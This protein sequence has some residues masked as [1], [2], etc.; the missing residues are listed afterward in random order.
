[1]SSAWEDMTDIEQASALELMG[2]KRQANILSSLIS[3][4]ETVEEV[5][6]TSANSSGSAMAENEK[7]MDSIAGKSEQLTNSMQ[8]MWNNALNSDAIKYFLTVANNIIKVVDSVGLLTTALAGV[9][10]Y[11]FVIKRNSPTALWQEMTTHINNYAMA[12][13]QVGALKSLNINIGTPGTSSFNATAVNQYAAAVSSLSAK[14]QA[15][16]LS[17]QGLNAEQVRSVL[18]ANQVSDADI[19]MALA[20]NGLTQATTAST[21]A[22]G[23]LLLAKAKEKSITL[24]EEAQNYLLAHSI[25]T[26][27]KKE[28]A[29]AVVKGKISHQTA[30]EIVQSGILT[31]M[32]MKQAFSW[33]ALGTAIKT[34]FLSN[35]VGW[36]MTIISALTM[37]SPLFEDLF[38]SAEERLEDLESKWKELSDKITTASNDFKQLKSS[39]DEVIPRFA[40]L[41][42]GVDQF[43]NNMKLTDAEYEEFLSLNNQ[44]A[45]MF[46]EINNGMDSNG[47]AMLAL[48]LSA[49]TLEESLWDLVEAERAAANKEIADTMPDVL[50]NINDTVKTYKD[51]ISKVENNKNQLEGA[52]KFLKKKNYS[53]GNSVE[54][55]DWEGMNGQYAE[56]YKQWGLDVESITTGGP[57]TQKTTYTISGNIDFSQLEHNYENAIA[58]LDKEIQDVNNK[59]ASKWEQLNPVVTAWAQTDY[60]F[61]GL[62]DEMQTVAQAMIGNIDFSSLKDVDTQEEV[63][64]YITN[65]ILNKIDDLSSTAQQK[66]SS[67]MS[68]DTKNMSTQEYINE[69]NSIAKA[70]EGLDEG[71]TAT[72]ILKNTGYK[73]KIEEYDR[74]VDNIAE[75]LGEGLEDSKD[76]YDD[77]ANEYVELFSTGIATRMTDD[78]QNAFKNPLSLKDPLKL[79]G[80]VDIE[81]M[82]PIGSVDIDFSELDKL[83]EKLY[84]LEPEELTKAFDYV[85]K[86][87]IKTWDELYKAL[88][89]KTF[90][91]VLDY[92]AEKEGREK[93]LTAIEE[94][95]SATGLTSESIDNIKARYQ[96]LENYDPARLFEETANGIHLNVQALRELEDAYE[97]QN[98]KELD[99]KLEGLVN[100]YNDLTL[101]IEDCADAS[102]RASLYA[103][104]QNVLDQI[105]D[106]AEL[107]TQYAGLTSA[108]NKW[109]EAQSGPNERDMYEGVIS[110]KEELEDELSRGWLDESSRSYLELL[111]GQDLSTASYDKLLETYNKLNETV[112]GAGYDVFDFFTVD[113]DGKSTTAGIY[114]FLDTVKVAQEEL[115]KEWVKVGEDG[116]YVFDFG[117][118]GDKAVAEALGISEEL[119]Q[120]I[121]RAAADAGFEVNLDST[122]SELADF[123]DEV[124]T[125][126][127]RLKEIK[128]TEYTFNI[129]STDIKD[130][131]KQIEEAKTAVKNLENE[132]GTIKVGVDQ[133]DYENAKTLL[134]TL[135]YQKQT[136]DD[137]AVLKV[138][139]TNADAGIE[140]VIKKLVQFKTDYNNLEVQT[141][142]GADT[143]E[144]EA[145][146]KAAITSLQ[147]EDPKILADLGIDLTKSDA[148]INTAISNIAPE[149]MV[150]CGL[151]PT[152]I[153]E[154]Q[155]EETTKE[156]TVI[157]E[158]N[159]RAVTE[160]MDRTLEKP[161]K[162]IWTNETRGVK[163][164]FTAPGTITWS[165]AQKAN[166]TAHSSG[167]AFA[168]GS[169]GAP[170]TE[171]SLVG[172]L[173]P[174]ILVRN[175]RW[176]TVGENGAEF[177]QV[178]KGDIIFN[179]KQT[180]EL[181]SNGY[182][183][184]RGKSYASGTAYSSG[185]GPGRYTIT[186]AYIASSNSSSSDTKDS[187]SDAS[188]A[189]DD[190]EETLD[191]IEIRLEEINEQLDLM[192]A[193]LE[194]AVNYTHKNN[195]IDEIIGINNTKISNLTAGIKKY[196]D[197]AAKLLSKVPS[198][199]REAAQNGA[200]AITDFA[201]EANEATVEA[202]NNYRDWAQKVAD[203]KQQ[204]EEVKAEIK[205]LAI[206]KFDNAYNTGDIKS[207]IEDS[208]TEKLQTAVDYDEEKGLITSSAYYTAMMKNSNKKI[209]FLTT[210]RNA[211]QKE[212]DMAV[213]AGHI[214]KGSDEWH[215]LVNQMYEIDTA[216][217]EVSI[218]LEEFQNSINDIYWDNFDELINR[219]DYL[220]DET[221]SLI[222]LMDSDDLITEPTK[223]TYKNGTVE[224][225]TA[226]DVDWTDE[227]IASLGLYAQQM[228]IAEYQSKQYAKAIDDLNNDYK[229]GKYSEIEYL[230]KLNELKS[231]QYDSIE[232]YYDAQDAIVELNETRIDSIKEGIEAEID[233]YSELIDKKKE[234]LNVEKD[235]YDF[236]KSVAEQQ[237]SIADIQRKIAAL[238]GDNSASAVAKRKQLEAE[239]VEA[240]SELEENYYDRSVEK[241]QEAL[242]KEL[243]DF[244]TEKDAEIKK[245]DEYLTNVETVVADSLGIIQSNATGVY[246]TLNAKAQEYNLTLSDSILTPW[247]D[248]ALAVSDYQTTFDT[249][250]SSTMDQ[251]EA[252]KNKWQE[253]IDKMAETGKNTVAAINKENSSYNAATKTPAPAKPTT[254]TNKTTTTTKT[255]KT[256]GKINAGSAKIYS[257]IGGQG[258]GQYFSSDPI[259]KVLDIQGNWVKVRHHK[260]SSGVTG[261]FKKS[262]VKAYA[263]GSKG[264]DKDQWAIIDELGEE[265]QLV[266]GENGRLEYVK[267]GTGIV[268]AD[269]TER[270]MNLATNPQEMIDRNRPQ[271]TPHNSIVNNNMEF[272]IDASVGELIHVERLEGGD[273]KEIN[274]VID[275]AWDKKMQGLNNAIKKFSR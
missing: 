210:A 245:W 73:E 63:Q 209:E 154:Y 25:E 164:F 186:S 187:V 253:V 96:D 119:V 256:G 27:T 140:T 260:A 40:E 239:L 197:Y 208:K 251:L 47:N 7:W 261:W 143:T 265:L 248:G 235:L 193:K 145:N 185:G 92:N 156:A 275:K 51:S 9:A 173:G 252:L 146:V 149:L 38:K 166:G 132:D 20:K 99:K 90:D 226:D 170:K 129:N 85:K 125:V 159:A 168:G 18:V 220:K 200:I 118:D 144:A 150:K 257:S 105:N 29:H 160:W 114:N 91:V 100:Q 86:Y 71:W 109:Q 176:T 19:K 98:T 34:A 189:A 139:T 121:L 35:P 135:I 196:S 87:G 246:D 45:D 130:V 102:E 174:E 39:A 67:L 4:F 215:E 249:A 127:D 202:I 106:T 65:N 41:A 21:A 222:D 172:E 13:K 124:E 12:A 17:T 1:M 49:S 181:L 78:I 241:Q 157:W 56:L 167:S 230:E 50:T 274:K 234:E 61:Q 183:T 161:G 123:K 93:L 48:S 199:Y 219:L 22:T 155:A 228:E 32:N 147:Q 141:A 70:I 178:K 95:L 111:S 11:F 8:A 163:T 198:Q 179:H 240:Q 14:Q 236:Q 16:V 54:I 191:W 46:P 108:Y 58:G 255:I 262:D 212:L 237:K 266:P 97:D 203:L 3:N 194:N 37:L 2:G 66:L 69:I 134:A 254:T 182:V 268:P 55:T 158:N 133:E 89:N 77:V 175:G 76:D 153:E 184:S 62:S 136:L 216:I 113:E 259:Y 74:I 247:Q 192:N 107:A 28:L 271:I 126:N 103:Q 201:G 112:N 151:D 264:V 263:K 190:F 233:A 227:G 131:E 122:Y 75:I 258:Y 120:I 36:I 33:K 24:S 142:V 43:G 82:K 31:A 242:D 6:E 110:G 267:K 213:Q 26:I 84:S 225:W 177:T 165:G 250:M 52:Y 223:R 211:M 169:W 207:T 243:E 44:I 206:Q 79:V 5:I 115:G 148:E 229:A 270:L 273:L 59:I 72:D 10:T 60:T 238:S 88:E 81:P 94:S 272:K 221:Q 101:E 104:R 83:K 217:D 218:E 128:A 30:A 162:V 64:N 231:A 138:D 244:Q 195:I 180:E 137:S 204:L 224:Y 23:A 57:N 116:S 232:A 205:D 188:D 171:T 269:L 152:L 80:P 53:A 42:K 15:A 214:V 117:V 68:L